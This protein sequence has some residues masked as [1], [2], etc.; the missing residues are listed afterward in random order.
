VNESA[1]AYYAALAPHYDGLATHRPKPLQSLARALARALQLDPADLLADLCCG[2]GLFS[3]E[4]LR[5]VP[6]RSQIVAV[7]ASEPMLERIQARV[8]AGI[9]P[10]AMDA[11]SFAEFP[12]RYDKILLKDGIGHFPDAAALL[13][14]LRERLATGGRLL[15]ADLAPDSQTW[16]F[17]EARRRWE[18]LYRRPD[19]IAALM[20][21]S[22]LVAAIGSV[23][24]RQR[25]A[26]AD[27]IELVAKRYAPVL[28]TFDDAELRKGIDEIRERCAN[29]DR[30]ESVHRFDLVTGLRE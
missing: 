10:V 28:A 19:E 23:T 30:L 1:R 12:V 14:A 21:V 11:T 22:G 3:R 6:L 20:E 25:L 5:L 13:R 27:L 2:T 24:V 17:K 9:R 16:L 26:P 4:L 29:V 8:D 15:V 7:D 18:S